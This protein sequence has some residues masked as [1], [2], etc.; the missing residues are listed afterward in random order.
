MGSCIPTIHVG[1]LDL[2]T[3]GLRPASL[4]ASQLSLSSDIV[5]DLD[6]ITKGLRPGIAKIITIVTI[7]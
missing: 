6:L 4:I 5:G 1:D 3:K 7:R 2:I